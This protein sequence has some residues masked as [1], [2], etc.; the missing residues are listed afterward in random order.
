[1]ARKVLVPALGIVS[2]LSIALM[3][4]ATVALAGEQHRPRTQRAFALL[5]PT[6]EVPALSSPARGRFKA[7]LDAANQ[8]IAYELS[9][10]G[11][12]AAPTQAHIHIGQRG[13]NGGISL[14]LCGNP[15]TVPPAQVPQPPACPPAPATI[16]GVLTAAHVVGPAPQGIDPT[17]ST[18]NEFDAIVDL[19][20]DGLTYAN[21]HTTRFP[22]GEIRG[23]VDVD[24]RK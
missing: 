14:F 13:A 23:Q 16:T 5:E 17:S 7:T 19:L 15:P 21:V 2:L 8:T 22:A 20:R 9:Y 4:L 18:V 11:L 3:A 12:E 10:E 24:G 6:E 1:M